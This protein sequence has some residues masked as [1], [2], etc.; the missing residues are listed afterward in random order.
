MTTNLKAEARVR[1][2]RTG[3]KYTEARRGVLSERETVRER[4]AIE[5]VTDHTTDNGCHWQM[6][7][8]G[9]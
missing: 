9:R 2:R 7:F 6:S 5:R 8:A 1:M 3:E 4:D